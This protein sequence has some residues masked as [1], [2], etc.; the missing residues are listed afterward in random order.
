M[1]PRVSPNAAVAQAVGVAEVRVTYGRP[2]V[3]GREIFGGLVPYGETWRT[4][5]NEATTITLTADA[6]V[7]GQPLEAGTYG[8]F[9]IPGPDAW[10]IIFN[11]TAE[12]WG[13]FSYDA[14][15]DVL[16]VEVSPEQAP[17]H[18]LLTFVFEEVT[19][20][21]AVLALYWAETRVPIP[22]A[23][24]TEAITR[25]RAGAAAAEATDW[26][27]P[28]RYAAWALGRGAYPEAALDWA[29]RSVAIEAHFANTALKAQLL[30]ALGRYD[31]AV[32]VAEEALAL[33]EAQE[34][35]PRGVDRLREAV[36]EW[37][38]RL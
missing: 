14:S 1:L 28:Y 13:D 5:A 3:R 37:S 16:R 17:P 8:L 9:T 35:M 12:Q 26:R 18:E 19:D 24:D 6:T 23:F 4:G 34:E 29:D 15:Q 27:V 20:T 33:A 11:E 22:L 32:A 10:T 30:A 31:E 2:H 25:T 36:D 21:S 38:A 7:A